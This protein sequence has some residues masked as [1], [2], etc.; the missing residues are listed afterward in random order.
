MDEEVRQNLPEGVRPEVDR[1]HRKHKKKKLKQLETG[2]GSGVAVDPTLPR[3]GDEYKEWVETRPGKIHTQHSRK[4]E[5]RIRARLSV[6]V[7][8]WKRGASAPR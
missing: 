2:S 1:R 5:V 8:P 3:V 6:P 7:A 4:H